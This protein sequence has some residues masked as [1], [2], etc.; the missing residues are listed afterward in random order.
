M[1]GCAYGVASIQGKF[2]TSEEVSLSYPTRNFA[3]LGI[4]VTTF[5]MSVRQDGY[6]QNVARSFLP[7]SSCRHEDRTI[8]FPLSI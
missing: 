8:S 4:V 6:A 5:C 7:S 3:T 1:S 2:V